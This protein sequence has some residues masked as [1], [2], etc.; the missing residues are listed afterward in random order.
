MAELLQ[1]ALDGVITPAIEVFDFEEAPNLINKI[2]DDGIIGRAV[3]RI[4]N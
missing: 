1:F 3:V 4:P 2:K